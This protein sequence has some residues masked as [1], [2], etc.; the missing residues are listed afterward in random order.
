MAPPTQPD[1]SGRSGSA[2]PSGEPGM[3]FTSNH[4]SDTMDVVQVSRGATPPM[5]LDP[6]LLA[7]QGGMPGSVTVYEQYTSTTG[8]QTT[9][10]V[11]TY[12]V[13]NAAPYSLAS[14]RSGH[15]QLLPALPASYPFTHSAS[16]ALNAPPFDQPASSFHPLRHVSSQS[17]ISPH[18]PQT[19]D[20]ATVR[21]APLPLSPSEESALLEEHHLFSPSARTAAVKPLA[22]SLISPA[23]SAPSSALS[24]PRGEDSAPWN[25]QLLR[26]RPGATVESDQPT[27]G[28][29]SNS[30][31]TSSVYSD[32]DPQPTHAPPTDIPAPAIRH[33]RRSSDFLLSATAQL[34]GWLTSAQTAARRWEKTL[35][36]KYLPVL[37]PSSP[38]RAH[39]LP[40]AFVVLILLL[41][42]AWWGGWLLSLQSVE[43]ALPITPNSA[44]SSASASLLW[45]DASLSTP[46][47]N[48]TLPVHLIAACVNRLP[49]LRTALPT[50]LAVKEVSS[51]TIVDW[52]SDEP[53]HERLTNELQLLDGRLRVVRLTH[54]H[55]WML[56]TAV[57]LALHFIPLD[58]PS[59]LLEGRLRHTVARRVCEEASDVHTALLRGRLAQSSRRERGA[60]SPGVVFINTADPA[61][62]STGTMRGCSRT[63]NDDTNLYDRLKAVSLIMQPRALPVHTAPAARRHNAQ[64]DKTSDTRVQ[65]RRPLCPS[66]PSTRRPS[67][68]SSS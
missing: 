10:R 32:S 58:T 66:L 30:G 56:P 67:C 68:H 13:N 8:D 28:Q 54:K 44:A 42:V 51:V 41:V 16:A 43:V 60:P 45:G 63:G 23:T 48:S 5:S 17:S 59:L 49:A 24:S 36:A 27:D 38:L 53:L 18:S 47:G 25:T 61:A 29:D 35:F 6:R 33:L 15:G 12:V 7:A 26:R 9:T 37:S 2:T 50:W 22:V 64:D 40:L 34:R 20:S 62:S 11:V 65:R 39:S 14:P 3:R 1:G 55:E 57:N 21:P 46:R 52:G 31:A 19:D 4:S